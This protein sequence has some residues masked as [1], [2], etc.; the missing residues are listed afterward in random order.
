MVPLI[1]HPRKF[2]GAIYE[3]YQIWPPGE[4]VIITS[5]LHKFLTTFILIIISSDS[6]DGDFGSVQNR[7]EEA[8][9]P[10]WR[11]VAAKPTISNI[12]PHSVCHICATQIFIY[13]KLGNYLK[14]VLLCQNWRRGRFRTE[15]RDFRNSNIAI[16]GVALFL[17]DFGTLEISIILP[18][19]DTTFFF[20]PKILG[21]DAHLYRL[22]SPQ[23]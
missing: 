9:I 22:L 1:Y 11:I 10:I 3:G 2:K 20:R 7:G 4:N 17:P 12:P 15:N 13:E 5:I 18:Y 23:I 14:N 6:S 16:S 8:E 19:L 21:V